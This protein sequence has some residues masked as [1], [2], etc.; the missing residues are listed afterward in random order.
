MHSVQLPWNPFLR[1]LLKSSK[2]SFTRG[3]VLGE[4]GF[5]LRGHMEG[6]LS[7][8][9]GLQSGVVLH[10]DGFTWSGGPSSGWV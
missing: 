4:G 3:V 1:P 6:K 2:G 9:K 5:D 7:E 10:H 8:K